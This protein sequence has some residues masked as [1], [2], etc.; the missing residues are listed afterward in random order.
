MKDVRL[1]QTFKDMYKWEWGGLSKRNKCTGKGQEQEKARITTRII[2]LEPLREGSPNP[3]ISFRAYVFT[4]TSF[5]G[6]STDF[7]T[8]NLPPL[9]HVQNNKRG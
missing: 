6:L 5:Q 7:W 4:H 3:S 2:W 1:S 9:L 8:L